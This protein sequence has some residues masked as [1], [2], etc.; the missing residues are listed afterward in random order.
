MQRDA[1]F[2]GGDSNGEL[3]GRCGRLQND[4]SLKARVALEEA[5]GLFDH[6][7]QIGRDAVDGIG[8]CI[9]PHAFD[10]VSHSFGLCVDLREDALG[11]FGRERA[12]GAEVSQSL[13]VGEDGADGLSDF[14][15]EHRAQLS[16][17]SDAQKTPVAFFRLQGLAAQAPLVFQRSLELTGPDLDHAAQ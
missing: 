12:R 7:A 11:Y 1:D 16:E 3:F 14:V 8:S 13:N 4:L 2:K 10:D 6:I 5:D 9:E 15:R 17:K